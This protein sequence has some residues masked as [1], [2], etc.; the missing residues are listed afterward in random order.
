MKI[1]LNTPYINKET[2][3]NDPREKAPQASPDALRAEENKNDVVR[4]SDRSRMIAKA[5]ELA[6][7]AP[8]IR[9]AKVDDLKARIGAGTYSVSGQ[10]VADSMLRKSITEV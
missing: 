1:N 6:T 3:A 8:D 10:M 5:T 2:K 4:L 9:A 7:N